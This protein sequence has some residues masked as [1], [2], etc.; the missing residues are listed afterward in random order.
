MLAEIEERGTTAFGCSFP[1][2]RRI[3]TN[4]AEGEERED[5]VCTPFVQVEHHVRCATGDSKVE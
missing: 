3:L 1:L 4:T 2:G 5:E